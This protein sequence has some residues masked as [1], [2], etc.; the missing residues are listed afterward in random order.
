MTRFITLAAFAIGLTAGP[1]GAQQHEHQGGDRERMG[2]DRTMMCGHMQM[3]MGSMMDGQDHGGMQGMAMRGLMMDVLRFQPANIL[4]HR[5][6]LD[7][8]DAQTSR[9]EE[10]MSG[11]HGRRAMMSE[12]QPNGERLRQLFE[13]DRPDTAALRAAGERMAGMHVQMQITHLVR[14]ALTR[15]ALT[16]AQRAQAAEF[17][18]G[19]PMMEH[20]GR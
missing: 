6:Q 8:T 4:E 12:M 1:L 9:I 10:L 19:C 7:L 14:A 18:T 20:E 11:H 16:P 13:A 17:G 15:A 3:M 5:S 2:D